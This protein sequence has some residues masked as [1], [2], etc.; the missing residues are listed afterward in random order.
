MK[1]IFIVFIFS[2]FISFNVNAQTYSYQKDLLIK[3]YESDT[4][5]TSRRTGIVSTSEKMSTDSFIP[6]KLKVASF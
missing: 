6:K 4:V 2:L 1:K 5:V 3:S